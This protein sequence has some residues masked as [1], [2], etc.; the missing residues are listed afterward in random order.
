MTEEE[1][2]VIEEASKEGSK[3]LIVHTN[4]VNYQRGFIAGAEF[5]LDKLDKPYKDLSKQIEEAINTTLVVQNKQSIDI[6][7][8]KIVKLLKAEIFAKGWRN[9]YR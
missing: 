6:A 2:K 8:S 5:A 7:V 9:H 3:N 1:R 4:N